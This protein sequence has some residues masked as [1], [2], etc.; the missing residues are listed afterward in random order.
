MT[1]VPSDTDK[2]RDFAELYT[3]AW[4]SQDPGAVASFYSPDG[5]LTINRGTPAIARTAIREVAQSFMSAFPDMRV[6]MD[7]VIQRDNR[8]EYHWTL[9]GT[10]NGPGGTGNRVRISGFEVWQIGPDG[11]IASSQAF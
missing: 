5:S 1:L 8:C 2:M 6:M 7:E 4:C 10:N 11:L 3:T 9:T